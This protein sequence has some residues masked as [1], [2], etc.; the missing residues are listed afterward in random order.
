[1]TESGQQ[2]SS[3]SDPNSYEDREFSGTKAE[4]LETADLSFSGCDFRNCDFSDASFRGSHF[5]ECTFQNCDL[6]AVDLTNAL[7]HTVTFEGSRLSGAAFGVL[8]R[9]TVGPTVTFKGCDLYLASFRGLDLR[10]C[11]FLSSVAREAEFVDCDLRGVDLSGSD[12]SAA[13]F[14]SSD[15]R[16]ADLRGARNYL[17]SPY[18]NNVR[19]AQ[20][21]LPEALGL[22]LGLRVRLHR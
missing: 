4:Q 7:L 21:E 10:G 19:G 8:R 3:T 11:A 13:R 12:F 17:L 5:T 15:L 2:P 20:V 6:S 18:E 16:D 9:D 22:L 14:Q 1:M